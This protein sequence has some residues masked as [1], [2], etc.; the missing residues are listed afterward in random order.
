MKTGP[1]PLRHRRRVAERAAE[2]GAVRFLFHRS[3]ISPH[4]K[5]PG[6]G[7]LY[8]TYVRYVP[9]FRNDLCIAAG[10]FIAGHV[11]LLSTRHEYFAAAAHEEEVD[12]EV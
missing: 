8:R 4:G 9:R 1:T 3:I 11:A 7:L 2:V 5:S 12:R 10:L 6:G